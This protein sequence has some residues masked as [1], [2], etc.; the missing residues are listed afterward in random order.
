MCERASDK[1]NSPYLS[2]VQNK[3]ALEKDGLYG[4]DFAPQSDTQ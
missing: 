3:L 2:S 1:V 4:L